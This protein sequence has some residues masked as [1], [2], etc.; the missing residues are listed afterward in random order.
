MFQ[1]RYT[2]D[3]DKKLQERLYI[4]TSAVDQSRSFTGRN[5]IGSFDEA[6]M[7]MTTTGYFRWKQGCSRQISGISKKFAAN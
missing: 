2:L 5:F 4:N 3:G 1:R 7:S 6:D